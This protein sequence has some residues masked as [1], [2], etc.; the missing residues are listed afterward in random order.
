[1]SSLIAPA[2]LDELRQRYTSARQAVFAQVETYSTQQAQGAIGKTLE[3]LAQIADDLLLALWQ[4][5]ALHQT[6]LALLAVGGYGRREL[7]PHSDIDVLVLTP[8]GH[9]AHE[10]QI[11]AFLRACWDVGMALAPSV[12]SVKQCL[13]AANDDITVQTA[14]LERRLLTG[15]ARLYA[16]LG[17]KF[18]A[19]LQPLAF[20]QAK[21]NE[22]QERHARFDDTPYALEP[23]C[24]ESPGGLRDLH[25]V[26]WVARAAGYGSTWQALQDHGLLT[27]TE[28]RDMRRHH[29]FLNLVRLHLHLCAGRDEN[30]LLFDLQTQVAQRL[31]LE[32][33]KN[34]PLRP[35][36][37]L[38]RRYYA[39]AKAM[40]QL[41]QIALL[42]LAERLQASPG[43]HGKPKT[44]SENLPGLSS[45]EHFHVRNGLLAIQHKGLYQ[46]HPHAILETFACFQQRQDV[47]GLAANTLRALYH[48]RPFMD[49]TWRSDAQHQQQFLQI[50]QTPQRL[51][52]TLEL[53]NQTSVLG[54][55]LPT[56]GRIVGQM[57]H[58]LFHVYTVDQHIL[59]VVR[60]VLQF[61]DPEHAHEHPLCARLA[62][63]WEQPCLLVVAALF[64][65]IA[66]GRNGDHSLLGERAVRRFARQHRLGREISSLL[67]FLVREHLS[68]SQVAQ[69]QDLGDPAVIARFADRVG[70]EQQLTA[71]YL[72]TVADIRG[73][74]PKLWSAWKSH[75]LEELYRR[76]LDALGGQLPDPA[77]L[78][79]A[80]SSG[81]LIEMARRGPAPRGH[82]RLWQTLDAGYFLRHDAQAIAW[83]TQEIAPHA[84]QGKT[85]VRAR[86][87]P[88]GEGLEV[89]VYT[90]DQ[91]AL[92]ARLCGFF[93]QA[94]F[95]ILEA[96]IH[97]S[98]DGYALDTFHITHPR[99]PGHHAGF[100]DTLTASLPPALQAGQALPRLRAARLSRRARSFPL[101]PKVHLQADADLKRWLLTVHASDRPG[102]L[103]A[104]A[105]VLADH[106]INLEL[107]KVSTMGERV[108]D[109]FLLSAESLAQSEA[110][111]QLHD[112]LLHKLAT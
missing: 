7:Q 53:M 10:T 77:A 112:D 98:N 80:R 59:R 38:M 81:A 17:H 40:T 56:F 70:N 95:S 45:D 87:A 5:H 44:Q 61:F 50:L 71:L 55:Y 107:A 6:P 8:P 31:G 69:K 91:P 35:G 58:D 92:F 16:T 86:P 66:K 19:A 21:L 27:A 48:A 67:A 32:S 4:A 96:R 75:L 51:A 23:N 43:T 36:E 13:Q 79:Q 104:I 99:L 94:G 11:A 83:H 42:T 24:K 20:Y 84:G 41:S 65:D 9:A 26:A 110:R 105:R 25:T 88:Q 68:L 89:L 82:L 62:A 14:V 97:T 37:N 22:M 74:S 101:P 33:P 3:A 60:Q 12:R 18:D 63:G 100:I 93:A 52:D 39:S 109:S 76:T 106:G 102:L 111:Q 28:R 54:R 90:P 34:T 30:R 29:A 108:E 64:H 72:L 46:Q 15:N 85:V 103:Y 47:H 49:A 2:H 57:Q 73:T 1:M 78:V